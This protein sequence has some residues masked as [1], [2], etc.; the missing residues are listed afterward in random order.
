MNEPQAKAL[1]DLQNSI[2]AQK[3]RLDGILAAITYAPYGFS[4]DRVIFETERKILSSMLRAKEYLE[5]IDKPRIEQTITIHRD[6]ILPGSPLDL[7]MKA[8]KQQQ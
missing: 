3:A 7:K 1:A 8:H 4:E 5:Q 6:D 2:G